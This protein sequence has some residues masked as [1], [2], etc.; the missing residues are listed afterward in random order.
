MAE[1]Q[2]TYAASL[3]DIRAAA[4]RI[5]DHAHVTPVLT[6]TT[7]DR[8]AGHKLKFKCEIFQ[9]G[10]AFKFRGAFNSVQQLPP[11][12]AKKGVVTHSSGNHAAA[13]ALAAQL[14][15]IPAY[16]VVPSNAPAC[17]LAAVQEYGGNLILCEPSMGARETTAA[18][19]AAVTGAMF[20]PPYDCAPVIA[21]Q[22]T[23]GLELLQQVPELDVV[24][25][26]V[27][28]GGMLSGITL[29][30]KALKPGILVLAAEPCG[31]NDA[32][33]VAASKR[34]GQLVADLPK[35]ITIA[36]G[37]QARL[38]K[39]TWPVVR[40]LVDGVVTVSDGDIV[41]AM[42]LLFERM[43]LVVEPSGAAG[44]A[45]V[46]SKDFA[47]A[48]A[49]AKAAAASRGTAAAAAAA[50]AV[51]SSE[52]NSSQH[53]QQQQQQQQQPPLNIGIILCGGNLDFKDFWKLE[54]W[55]PAH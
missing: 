30:A 43:K 18:N 29:A 41:A 14:R 52:A 51:S 39:H 50:A 6:S 10:G 13:L 22:G 44:L 36:D 32:A 16:I 37:L 17:K 40:D 21:G 26:P 8:L 9:K 42:Q 2:T 28:G 54:N 19:I 4:Q 38:G 25:V 33:D 34:A 5:S 27:S 12:Q 24:V 31:S 20:I 7:L 45:A 11:E 55:Q 49:H 47:A 48:I 3:D 53:E 23:I 46:L 15:G 35:P 1:Q